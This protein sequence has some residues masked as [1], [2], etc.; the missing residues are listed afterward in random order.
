MRCKTLTRQSSG[1][2]SCRRQHVLT[3]ANVAKVRGTDASLKLLIVLLQHRN[4]SMTFVRH[5]KHDDSE[6]CT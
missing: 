2:T 5:H 1:S 4:L 6:C 3:I